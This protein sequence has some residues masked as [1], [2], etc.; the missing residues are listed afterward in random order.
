MLAAA[1]PGQLASNMTLIYGN[2]SAR[3][4]FRG[5]IRHKFPLIGIYLQL[6]TSPTV[7]EQFRR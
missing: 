7:A 5:D 3:R 6:L 4:Q 2:V 1:T